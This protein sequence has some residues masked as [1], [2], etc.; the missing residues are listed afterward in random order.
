MVE[1]ATQDD[2]PYVMRAMES[3]L[4]PYY[5]G[6]H[7]AHAKRL[8]RTHLDGGADRRGSLSARQL[9][10]ILWQHGERRGVLNLVFKRQDTCKISPLIVH[11]Q[12]DETLGL[13]SVLLAAAEARAKLQRARQLY[14]TVPESNRRSLEFFLQHGFVICG[15]SPDQYKDG[16]RE[17][18]LRK[19]L[20]PSVPA[21]GSTISVTRAT[22]SDWAEVRRFLLPAVRDEVRGASG[23]WLESLRRGTLTISQLEKGEKRPAWV[24]AAR[25]R[26]GA[27]RAAAIVSSKKGDALKV[28]P[29][30]AADDEGFEALIVDLPS[31]L[32]GKGRKAYVHLVPDAEQVTLLQAHGWRLEAMLPGAYHEGTVTQQWAFPLR[33]SEYVRN[34]RIR[35]QYLQLIASGRKSLEIRVAYEHLRSIKPGDRLR[36]LS[37]SREIRCDVVDVRS[38]RSFEDMLRKE[39]V[40]RALPG[41]T[42]DDALVRLREIYP[43]AKERLGILVIELRKAN[44]E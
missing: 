26:T 14:C 9:L 32:K 29:L 2:T 8:I 21:E 22:E 28:M 37:A 4:A 23:Q 27:V 39:D 41:T 40:D 43:P 16:E 17:V 30:A 20:E 1:P 34:L 38:Y 12:S 31:L 6:D 24:F 25:D 36:L 35:D 7:R 18:F 44:S 3:A 33:G 10:L 42:A 5:G 15:Y 13:G 11:P 19:P